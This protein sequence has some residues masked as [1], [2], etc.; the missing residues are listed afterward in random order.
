MGVLRVGQFS[1]SPVLIAARQ[2]GWDAEEGLSLD[3]GPVPS[4]PAQFASLRDRD[5]DVALTSPDNV[6]L[7]ASTT[8]NPLGERLPLRIHRGIDGGL[9]LCL[10]AGPHVTDPRDF[11]SIPVAVDVLQSGFALLLKALLTRLGVQPATV[12]FVEAGATPKRAELLVQ[13]VVGATILNAESR[14]RA[15]SKGMKVW[16]TS[17]D[18][19][20][21][22]PGT[23]LATLADGPD[24]S[25]LLR[26]W[27]RTT[28]WLLRAPSPEVQEVL[29][30]EHEDLGAAAYLDLLRAPS[31][32]LRSD[33]AVT[34]EELQVL[35]NLRCEAGAFAPT[36]EDMEAL[37]AT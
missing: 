7:Y 19:S 34:V 17:R 15:E 37:A 31:L 28:S 30:R 29:G 14:V 27:E 23:V 18:I 5:I 1:R 3:V 2:L 9:G 4:S 13:G 11:A 10:M 24:V 20:P 32:G 6:L 25:A 21:I 35:A 26:V 22:Y 8:A 12:D 36:V 33:P 16:S